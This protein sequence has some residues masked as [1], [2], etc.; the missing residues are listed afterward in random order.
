C[1]E[2]SIRRP[3]PDLVLDLERPPLVG[4]GDL[5]T[6]AGE[7]A[8][9]IFVALAD[10]S[11]DQG[12]LVVQRHGSYAPVRGRWPPIAR[13]LPTAAPRR[14]P[15]ITAVTDTRRERAAKGKLRVIPFGV[16]ARRRVAALTARARAPAGTRRSSRGQ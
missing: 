1:V 5:G 13:I 6:I 10:E 16:A 14:T 4:A 9:G 8:I 15:F 12:L 2:C 7:L 11:C 3:V